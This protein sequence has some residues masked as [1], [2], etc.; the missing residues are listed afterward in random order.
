MLRYARRNANDNASFNAAVD[1][2]PL[3]CLGGDGTETLRARVAAAAGV[4]EKDILTTDI[5][6]YNTQAGVEWG[7][8]I[9]APRLD[10]LQCAYA[11]LCAF[12]LTRCGE[13][14]TAASVP[15]Y[16][17]FDNEEVG[18]QTKQGAASTFL[19]DV[20]ERVSAAGRT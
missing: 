11:S 4:D 9:S 10:D 6:V 8:L 12:A 17:L 18:S 19:S 5:S 7:T 1:M 3:Y 13:G 15:V 16:C 20:L 14:M 2:L